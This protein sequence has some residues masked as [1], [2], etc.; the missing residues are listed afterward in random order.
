MEG[1]T[2]QTRP[3]LQGGGSW[4]SDVESPLNGTRVPGSREA[5]RQARVPR[6]LIWETASSQPVRHLNRPPPH[7]VLQGDRDAK[8]VPS[9]RWGLR[10][11]GARV[12]PYRVSEARP[13]LWMDQNQQQLTSTR[14]L[15]SLSTVG[16]ITLF[17]H[18]H[19]VIQ[20][21]LSLTF[22]L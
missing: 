18:G 8:G 2:G 20:V 3:W 21:L 19:L 12:H 11:D 7:S 1:G 10:T 14:H 22:D 13:E 17:L 16:D 5:L 4:G 9:S 6:E 15:L